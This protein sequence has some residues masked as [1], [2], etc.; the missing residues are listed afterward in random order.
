MKLLLDLCLYQ[1]QSFGKIIISFSKI[2]AV[3]LFITARSMAVKERIIN[4]IYSVK[5]VRHILLVPTDFFY[6]KY[7]LRTH[8]RKY[9]S[10]QVVANGNADMTRNSDDT[11]ISADADARREKTH[12]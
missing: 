12:S 3:F 8:Y 7:S 10:P 11:M 1:L 2:V 5:K 9:H 6:S 4:V